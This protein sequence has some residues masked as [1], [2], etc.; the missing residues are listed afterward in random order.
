MSPLIGL[1]RLA[2]IVLRGELSAP[3]ATPERRLPV[4]ASLIAAIV[5][6]GMFYGAVMGS[7]GGANGWRLWQAVYS[8]AKVPLLLGATFWLSLPFFFVL[9][10]LLGLRDDFRRV[11]RAL[12]GTQAVLTLILASLAPITAFWYVSTTDYQNAIL[13][14]GEMFAIASFGAQWLLRREYPPFAGA[15]RIIDGCC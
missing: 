6:Y 13:F 8:A 7:Y 11:V 3:G 2:D 12:A 4:L 1:F 10:T 5:A 15:T 9:N 14:N